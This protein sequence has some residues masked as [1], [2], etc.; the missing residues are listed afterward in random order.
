MRLARRVSRLEAAR[1]A[2]SSAPAPAPQRHDFS[3]L[4]P[5]EQ[6]ELDSLLAKQEAGEAWTAEEARRFDELTATC[7]QCGPRGVPHFR[8]APQEAAMSGDVPLGPVEPDPDQPRRPAPSR[9]EAR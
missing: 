2:P 6:F 7:E 3:M 5:R 4:T 8:R 1:P 9:E